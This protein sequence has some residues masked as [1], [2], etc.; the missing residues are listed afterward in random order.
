LIV[1]NTNSNN[2]INNTLAFTNEDVANIWVLEG[3]KGLSYDYK[4]EN[5]VVKQISTQLIDSNKS[6]KKR[7]LVSINS[8]GFIIYIFLKDDS[9]GIKREINILPKN[10]N[11]VFVIVKT[12]NNNG[13]SEGDPLW[14]SVDSPWLSNYLENVKKEFESKL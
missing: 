13:S 9:N 1:R 11:S 14:L 2:K 3:N 6:G 7:T 8:G 4:I 12:R 10:D 5:D